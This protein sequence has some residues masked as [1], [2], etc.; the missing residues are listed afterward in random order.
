M[1][2]PEVKGQPPTLASFHHK[3]FFLPLQIPIKSFRFIFGVYPFD[4]QQKHICWKE[5]ILIEKHAAFFYK[6]QKY[7][8]IYTSYKFT[9][10][11]ISLKNKSFTTF[12]RTL[13]HCRKRNLGLRCQSFC[14]VGNFSGFSGYIFCKE[15]FIIA[16]AR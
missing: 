9:W 10:G 4:A 7:V 13:N 11:Q 6:V 3:E 14:T 2:E 5:N 12:Q 8:L 1:D 16:Q 15:I